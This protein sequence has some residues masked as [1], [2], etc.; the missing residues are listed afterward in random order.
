MNTLNR[1]I[2][3]LLLLGM[4]VVV[5]AVCISPEQVLSISGDWLHYLGGYFSEWPVWLR[6]VVGIVVALICDAIMALGIFFEVRPKPK[7]FI[8]VQQAS[9]GMVTI[10]DASI[11]QQLQHQLDPVPGV[12]EVK[13]I[14]RARGNKVQALVHVSVAAGMSVPAMA[15]HLVEKVQM[16]LTDDLGLKIY[17]APEVRIKVAPAPEGMIVPPLPVKPTPSPA[18]S[19]G[20]PPLPDTGADR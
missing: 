13:P 12:I 6:I 10:N 19:D 18:P 17:K 5:T 8:R 9:G 20:P 7:R 1:I 14:I 11:V 3:V 15:N 16:I 4:M 2:V